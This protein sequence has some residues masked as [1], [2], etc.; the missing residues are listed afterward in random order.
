MPRLIAIEGPESGLALPVSGPETFLAS[1]ADR[2][3]RLVRGGAGPAPASAAVIRNSGAGAYRIERT[4]P[5][6][7]GAPLLF[8]NGEAVDGAALQHGDMIAYGGTTLIFDCEPV[9]ETDTAV[10]NA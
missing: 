7:A 8:V 3:V 10:S 6:G 4:A 5:P 1:G 9:G 2:R